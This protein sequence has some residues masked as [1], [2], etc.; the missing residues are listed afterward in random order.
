[1]QVGREQ[2]LQLGAPALRQ[3]SQRVENIDTPAFQQRLA[4]L[5]TTLVAFR[6]AHG[7]GRAIAAPQ[8]GLAERFIAIDL[9]AGP[10]AVINPT[11]TWRSAETFTL[12]DDCMSFPDLLVKVRR[13]RSISLQYTDAEG[14]EHAWREL[15]PDA[16]ELLQHELD[17]LDGVLAVDRAKQS[18]D[19]VTRAAFAARRAFYQAQVDGLPGRLTLEL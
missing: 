10:F 6:D 7:F 11:V 5:Q 1:M 2:V 3:P 8:I 16:A 4:R 9:G 12:W 14:T 15:A 18:D 17:H 13:H 19:I